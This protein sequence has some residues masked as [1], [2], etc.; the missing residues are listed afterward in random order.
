MAIVVDVSYNSFKNSIFLIQFEYSCNISHETF[1][2]FVLTE[3]LYKYHKLSLPYQISA[4]KKLNCQ[5]EADFISFCLF[6]PKK[7]SSRALRG[8]FI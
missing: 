6:Y 8:P 7:K 2:E 1:L 3:I 4:G 5:A